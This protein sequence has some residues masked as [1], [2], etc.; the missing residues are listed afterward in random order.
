M[1]YIFN[2]V[3]NMFEFQFSKE[4]E[5]VKEKRSSHSSYTFLYNL[6]TLMSPLF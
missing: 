5:R 4:R 6:L 2:L 3:F 1:A